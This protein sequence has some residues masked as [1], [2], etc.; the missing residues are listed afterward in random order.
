VRAVSKAFRDAITTSSSAGIDVDAAQQQHKR[1][2]AAL[3]TA[4]PS[5]AIIELDSPDDL[6]DACFVEDTLVV[7]PGSW[8]QQQQPG[9]RRRQR[10]SLAVV[11]RPP[12][13]SRAGET[14]GV[15]KAL[16]EDARLKEAVEVVGQIASSGPDAAL[17]GGD[18]LILPPAPATPAPPLTVLVGITGRTNAAGAA[19]LRDLLRPHGVRVV[20]VPV[21]AALARVTG[22]AAAGPT[23]GNSAAHHQH[24]FAPLHLKSAVTA[25]AHDALLCADG[26]AGRAVAAAVHGA[27]LRA[28]AAEEAQRE[29]GGGNTGAPIASLPTFAFVPEE[30]ACAA[31]VVLLGDAVIAQPAVEASRRVLEHLCGALGRRLVLIDPPLEEMKK[32]DGALTCCSVLL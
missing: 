22:A 16:Q 24:H 6:P 12:A 1:Y 19:R 28:R 2:V 13:P 8:L 14:E 15:L 18:V 3:R 26:A 7:V 4:S 23:A 5:M 17:D 30:D 29:D 10:R 9:A 27:L 25:L 32:A 11:T 21:A 20:P 31:N